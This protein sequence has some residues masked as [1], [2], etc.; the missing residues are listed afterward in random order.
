M[1]FPPPPQGPSGISDFALRLADVIGR[2]GQKHVH[3]GGLG[4]APPP[5]APP[6]L[7]VPS[8]LR[9]LLVLREA[10]AEKTESGK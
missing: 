6:L 2:G 7:V 4:G 5:A 1:E 10:G 9:P 3:G 8:P